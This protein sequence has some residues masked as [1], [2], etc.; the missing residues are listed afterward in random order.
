MSTVKQFIQR[1][2]VFVQKHGFYIV[3]VIVIPALGISNL[4]P[5]VMLGWIAGACTGF[6]A[7]LRWKAGQ[8]KHALIIV[9]AYLG[10]WAVVGLSNL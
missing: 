10:C 6:A 7:G 4:G 3:A 5:G 1:C 8:R 9:A 2:A